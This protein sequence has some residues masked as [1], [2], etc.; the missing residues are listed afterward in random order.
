MASRTRNLARVKR[1]L[2]LSFLVALR[3][4]SRDLRSS[5][6]VRIVAPETISFALYRMRREHV[7]VTASTRLISRSPHRVRFMATA[8]VTVLPDFVLSYD[9]LPLVTG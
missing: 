8:A 7:I 2:R 5:F 1:V 6:G 4:L 9:P 3:T